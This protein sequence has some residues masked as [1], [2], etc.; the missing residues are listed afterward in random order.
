[1]RSSSVELAV[2]SQHIIGFVCHSTLVLTIMLSLRRTCVHPPVS[3]VR[4]H[5]MVADPSFPHTVVILVLHLRHVYPPAARP[6]VLLSS[7]PCV[8]ELG[9]L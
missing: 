4:M 5:T 3:P 1:M 6:P 7:A 2:R 8:D 9:L